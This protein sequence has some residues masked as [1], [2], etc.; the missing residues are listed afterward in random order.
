MIEWWRPDAAKKSKY[1]YFFVVIGFEQELFAAHT[2]KNAR[3]DFLRSGLASDKTNPYYE[4]TKR[5][6]G[7]TFFEGGLEREKRTHSRGSFSF[8]KGASK[9]IKSHKIFL[10]SSCANMIWEVGFFFQI[11]FFKYFTWILNF[12]WW[13]K[14]RIMVRKSTSKSVHFPYIW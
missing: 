5:K 10:V 6:W 8:F 12:S 2:E 11:F 13:Q 7:E 14:K 4:V 3:A 9:E 1:I